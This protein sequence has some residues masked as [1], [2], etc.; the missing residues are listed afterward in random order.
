MMLGLG[1]CWSDTG[2]KGT[3]GG[4]AFYVRTADFRARFHVQR[5]RFFMEMTCF[6][7]Q[8]IP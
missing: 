7:C 1:G 5:P 8:N 3:F 2:I 4:K 6:R